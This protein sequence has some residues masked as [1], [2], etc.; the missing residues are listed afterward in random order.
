MNQE[1]GIESIVNQSN[2]HYEFL[3][4]S[5]F[6]TPEQNAKYTF[7]EEVEVNQKDDSPSYKNYNVS[8]IK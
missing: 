4:S 2:D 5:V 6:D 3:Q 8:S 7:G 1:E